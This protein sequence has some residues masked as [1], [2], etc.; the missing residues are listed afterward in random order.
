MTAV[1]AGSLTYEFKADL[2]DIKKGMA[3]LRQAFQQSGQQ[4]QQAGE[5]IAAGIKDATTAAQNLGTQVNQTRSIL[6]SFARGFAVGVVV[7]G[8]YELIRAAQSYASDLTKMGEVAKRTYQSVQ[9]LSGTLSTAKAAGISTASALK[10]IDALG[11]KANKEFRDGEGELTSWLKANNLSLT[12]RNGKL[13][14]TNDLLLDAARL[15]QNAATEYDKIDIARVF[16]LSEEWV[17]VLEKGPAALQQAQSDASA[18]G[19]TFDSDL[20]QKAQDFDKRWAEGWAS[21]EAHAKS[22]IQNAKGWLEDLIATGQKFFA[23]LDPRLRAALGQGGERPPIQGLD[24]T[25]ASDIII[26]QLRRNPPYLPGAM[27]GQGIGTSTIGNTTKPPPPKGGGGGGGGSSIDQIQRYIDNLEKAKDTLAAEVSTWGQGNTARQTA[28]NLIQLDNVA[29]RAG[30]TVTEEQR[31]KVKEITAAYEEQKTKLE[32][33]RSFQQSLNQVA[34]TFAS[35]LDQWIVQGGKFKEVLAGLL[36]QLASMAL[37]AALIGNGSGGKTG[38]LFGALFGALGFKGFATGG[39]IS[40]NSWAIVGEQGPELIRTGAQGAT[41]TSNRDLAGAVGGGGQ[42]IVIQ[43]TFTA[44][45]NPR[46]LAAIAGQIKDQ[47]VVA[48]K[49]AIA[50]GNL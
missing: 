44:D 27:I 21:F 18:L 17:K 26:G 33:L 43:Q 7:Q 15:V 22:A 23:G 37:Q 28:I 11:A 9:Q 24:D 2:S 16:G 42:P 38:G 45:A 8:F 46:E 39:Q 47:T 32:E 5:Q 14:S 6:G 30:V 3:D 1:A 35:A 48:V 34:Q 36:R 13:K 10:D 25:G 41:V 40:G 50:R 19:G 29:K 20:V 31:N 49:Q 12:D 4:A